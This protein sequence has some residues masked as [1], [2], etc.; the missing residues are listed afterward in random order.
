MEHILKIEEIREMETYP[1]GWTC[2]YGNDFLISHN[3]QYS[4]EYEHPYIQNLC[5]ALICNRGSASG[6]VDLQSYQLHPGNMMIVLPGQ[7][8]EAYEMSR[9]FKGTYI[10]MSEVFLIGLNIG[11]GYRFHQ[12]IGRSPCISL[13]DRMERAIR[14]YIDMSRSIMEISDHNPNTFESLQLLTRLFFLNMGWFLHKD[15]PV[16]SAENRQSVVMDQFIRQLTVDFKKHRDVEHYAAKLNLTPKYMSTL[17]KSASGKPAL[18]WIEEKVILYA[19]AQLAS[20]NYTVKQ[21]CYDLNF[22]NQSFFGR[23]F[24]RLT[25][26]SPTEYK[27]SARK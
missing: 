11:E 21:L 23:Y 16:E 7:I 5:V 9:D 2:G 12:S 18:Q 13:N 27:E 1:D 19:K 22:P 10:F 25:G 3:P 6:A 20:G 17:V 26:M 24:K 15:T 14:G 4:V 8:M